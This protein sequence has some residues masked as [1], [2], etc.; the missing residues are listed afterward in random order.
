MKAKI[1]KSLIL[2]TR[3]HKRREK[4][5]KLIIIIVLARFVSRT[6]GQ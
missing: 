6:E 3:E 4:G 1:S 5:I 2:G